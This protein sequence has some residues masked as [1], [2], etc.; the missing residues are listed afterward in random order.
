MHKVEINGA[1]GFVDQFKATLIPG[2]HKVEATYGMPVSIVSTEAGETLA[3]ESKYVR[4]V[5]Q[6]GDRIIILSGGFA[7]LEG[8]IIEVGEEEVK[9]AYDGAAAW[10]SLASQGKTWEVVA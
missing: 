3:I 10:E 5:P 7:G 9:V 8:T 1:P 4:I 6:A 2:L